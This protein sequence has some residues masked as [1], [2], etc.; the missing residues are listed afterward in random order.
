[1]TFRELELIAF[2]SGSLVH[3][4]QA[5]L[6]GRYLRATPATRRTEGW[7]GLV[8]VLQLF[9]WQ[10][11]N[12]GCVLLAALGL[13]YPSLPSKIGNLVRWGSLYA[14]PVMLSYVVTHLRLYGRPSHPRLVKAVRALR[15][16]LWPWLLVALVS[17]IAE[18]T[19]RFSPIVPFAYTGWIT[20]TLMLTFFVIMSIQGLQL[21]RDMG[22]S[23]LGRARRAGLI[24]SLVSATLIMLSLVGL[25][26]AFP[27]LGPYLSLAG[28]MTTVP[29]SIYLAYRYFQFPFMDV[30]IRE[31]VSG[32]VLVLGF[33]VSMAISPQLPAGMRM[34]WLVAVAL[35]LAF[36][37]EPLARE[38]E[39]RLL[40][41]QEV[42]EEQ[43]ERVGRALR[44]LTHSD[45]FASQAE[46]ILRGE[47]EAE[48]VAIR[49]EHRPD[50]VHRF[51][52]KGSVPGWLTLGPRVGQRAY[53]SRQ[54]RLARSAALQLAAQ[55]EWLHNR[56]NERRRLVEQHQ[57]RELT[58]RA[59][60]R[61]LQAQIN[62][63]FLFNTLNVLANLIQDHPDVAERVT[64]QL[65]E[66]FRYALE[67]TRR[68]RVSLEEEVRF[69]QAYL[70]IERA[71]FGERLHH[72][73]RV[74]SA[75]A[76]VPIVPMLLQPLVENAVRHGIAPALQ[77]GD[78]WV[79]AM[80]DGKHLVL[81]VED[82]GVGLSANS[83]K[84]GFGV[85]LK[86]VRERLLRCYGESAGL[87]VEARKP[88]GTRAAL[89]LPL[90]VDRRA[91]L[92]SPQEV[93]L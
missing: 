79:S 90:E 62:P 35:S 12:F 26:G 69:L 10:F 22:P 37:K 56:D 81:Q 53:M 83:S 8:S 59:E 44:G 45:N 24:A 89:F 52:L 76:G 54:L 72:H 9:A 5:V 17:L 68:E 46:D 7:Q 21:R 36:A 65:A 64:E 33:V 47:L 18:G 31:A 19:K 82:S 85:G 2:L 51:E 88:E 66:V 78:V 75:V 30:Y 87:V 28:M 70:E 92:V 39:R 14:T 73:W 60:M 6:I 13:G 74:D 15:C 71:R 58:A 43:E 93:S 27:Q 84:A 40:G 48:W 57:L 29:F 41:Y 50:A 61:A 63:H 11:S 42:V 1:M 38:A 80:F 49:V 16:L 91:T 77:G 34:L 23:P 25:M 20:L 55:Q 3:G 4:S 67:S 86:N 32:L